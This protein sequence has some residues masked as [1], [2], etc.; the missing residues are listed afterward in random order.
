MEKPKGQPGVPAHSDQSVR[1]DPA[2]HAPRAGDR[3]D[4]GEQPERAHRVPNDAPSGATL[5]SATQ[6]QS[7]GHSRRAPDP[8]TTS[9]GRPS[10]RAAERRRP[11][12]NSPRT[13]SENET[14]DQ[15]RDH[16]GRDDEELERRAPTIPPAPQPARTA[17]SGRTSTTPRAPP[18]GARNAHDEPPPKRTSSRTFVRRK[19]DRNR[20]HPH[21]MTANA[22]HPKRPRSST[23]GTRRHDEKPP[24]RKRP[25]RDEIHP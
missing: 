19:D 14:G 11:T 1:D 13:Q 21:R 7:H 2:G 4:G 15:D 10:G 12:R 25:E 6:T 23:I 5:K 17:S 16:A 24:S 3:L 22:E 8:S 20:R 9:T 18:G